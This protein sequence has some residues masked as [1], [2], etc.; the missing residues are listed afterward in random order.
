M[1]P[2]AGNNVN[3]HMITQLPVKG[4]SCTTR[5]G[6][7]RTDSEE[8]ARQRSLVVLIEAAIVRGA[9]HIILDRRDSSQNPSDVQ[10]IVRLY[11]KMSVAGPAYRHE[12]AAKEPLLWIPDVMAWSIARGGEWRHRLETSQDLSEVI[13]VS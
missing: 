10:T 5:I 9:T 12:H 11:E 2:P 8:D 7:H 6:D 3:A 1:T 13:K 4:L